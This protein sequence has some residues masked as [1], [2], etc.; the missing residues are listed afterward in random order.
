[1]TTTEE[2]HYVVDD[3]QDGAGAEPLDPGPIREQDD[4]HFVGDLGPV[5]EPEPPTPTVSLEALLAALR[6]LVLPTREVAADDWAAWRVNLNDVATMVVANRQATRTSLL[7]VNLSGSATA[8]LSSRANLSPAG[9]NTFPVGPGATF[10]LD[11]TGPVYGCTDA[12]AAAQLAVVAE[13]DT[14]GGG[15]L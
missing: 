8:Y 2:M 7:I 15:E 9:V 14:A 13:Y 10:T 3:P 4:G 12:G 11:A 6:K 1:M 5:P